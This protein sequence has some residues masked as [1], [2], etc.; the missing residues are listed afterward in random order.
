MLDIQLPD[1]TGVEIARQLR[2]RYEQ[3]EVDYLPLL[4]AL[5]ANIMQ[6][7]SEYQL[8]GMDDVLRKPL[9]LEAL[10][11]CLN[12]HF[13]ENFLQENHENPPLVELN[14]TAKQPFDHQILRELLAVMGKKALLANFKL[15]SD[16]MPEYLQK[17]QQDF[18]Q[19]QQSA[20]AEKRQAVAN[21]A[22]KIKGA[23]AAVGLSELQQVAQLA[24]NDNG[25]AWEKGI[26]GWIEQIA[27]NWQ[28]D[29]TETTDWLNGQ[30][31][32]L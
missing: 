26:A 25:T 17:L 19:W 9:S 6:T 31:E 16:L 22:H 18:R 4:I 29:L 32:N 13:S 21:E 7:K 24:Q 1:T 2:Q 12:S 27:Q 14:P 11:T 15:F 8:Q 30:E 5:T 23:L 3:G 10:A 28:A 20:S